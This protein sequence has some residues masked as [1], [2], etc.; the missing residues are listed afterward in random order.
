MMERRK[1]GERKKSSLG[2]GTPGIQERQVGGGPQKLG[3]L[4]F[5]GKKELGK[6]KWTLKG[7]EIRH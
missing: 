1:N 4:G 6:V 3:K 2:G 5:G 7:G